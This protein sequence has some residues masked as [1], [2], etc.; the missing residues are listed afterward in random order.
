[1]LKLVRLKFTKKYIAETVTIHQ[2]IV[3]YLCHS[4]K[5]YS[6]KIFLPKRE[7]KAES[8]ENKEEK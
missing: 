2:N 7:N 8:D 5:Q 6:I 3:I 4:V 1:M